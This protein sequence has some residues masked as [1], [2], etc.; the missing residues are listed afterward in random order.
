MSGNW[1]IGGALDAHISQFFA[2]FSKFLGYASMG[3]VLFLSKFVILDVIDIVFGDHV[4]LGHFL[5]V[6]LL[7]FSLMMVLALVAKAYE[8]L[9]V[10]DETQAT[11]AEASP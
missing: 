8:S 9:G 7:V 10:D 11:A 1:P 4:D 2:R 6:V 3:V 5:D